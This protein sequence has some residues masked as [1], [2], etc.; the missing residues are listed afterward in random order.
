MNI[1]RPSAI[2]VSLMV[3]TAAL[4]LCAQL[5]V[6]DSGRF[7]AAQEAA[8]QAGQVALNP[9]SDRY[10]VKRGD[11]LWDISMF[12][13]DPWYWPEIWYANPQVE[14]PHLIYPGDVLTWSMSTASRG[15]R[16]TAATYGRRR[17][18]KARP[19]SA[20][21][22]G[23]HPQSLQAIGIPG[24][25][26]IL[27]KDESSTRLTSYGSRPALDRRRRYDLYVRGDVAGDHGYSVVHIG[28]KL[29]DPDDVVGYQGLYVGAGTIRQRATRPRC[30][31]ETS[32]E[33]REGDRLI[34]EC[35]ASV[36]FHA[37][38][39]VAAGDGHHQR[40]VVTAYPRSGNNR[41][42]P[43]HTRRP[44]VGNVLRVWQKG[45][46][47]D[48]V[49]SG[50]TRA[51]LPDEPAGVSMFRTYDRQL[52][53]DCEAP[54][55]SVLIP[56]EP[57]LTPAAARRGTVR[58]RLV[59]PPPTRR[60][61]RRHSPRLGSATPRGSP[62]RSRPSCGRP[63][64]PMTYAALRDPDEAHVAGEAWLTAAADRHLVAWTTALPAAAEADPASAR[65][66]VRA[67]DPACVMLP[68]LAIVGSRNASARAPRRRTRC[69]DLAG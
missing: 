61:R 23:G 53:A 2:A 20:N 1:F 21:R 35:V 30:S 49:T 40:A 52:C 63:A 37:E 31:S 26:S 36:Q 42:Q 27:Q 60:V 38:R 14:N 68:Q 55:R 66:I 41:D 13:K 12:L 29:R 24:P 67:G 8:A 48:H 45:K 25:R 18:R 65:R 5:A 51:R 9:P 16:W 32:R 62:P 10:V 17:H 22:T 39:A 15:Y 11:T 59:D 46:R 43:R 50:L 7:P 19:R 56:S 44:A 69:R 57:D 54:A 33:A 4:V 3:S 6:P 34:S 64:F 28:D 58:A 47:L